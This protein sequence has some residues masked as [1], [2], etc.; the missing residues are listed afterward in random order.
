MVVSR[1]KEEYLVLN[2]PFSFLVLL[3]WV[4]KVD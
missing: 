3:E 2:T 4:I 1:L